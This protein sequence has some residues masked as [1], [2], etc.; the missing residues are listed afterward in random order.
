M[1]GIL[2]FVPLQRQRQRFTP[3]H[4]GDMP[5]FWLQRQPIA[6]HPHAC[7]GY[8]SQFILQAFLF[9]FTPTHV[10]DMR[11]SYLC[12]GRRSRFTPTHVGDILSSAS[13]YS[14]AMRFTPT[15]VGD[16][17]RD[18][19]FMLFSAVHPHACGGYCAR[20]ALR[21]GVAGSPPRMWGIYR[22][23]VGI[24]LA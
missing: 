16:I 17:K 13:A 20:I 1:W 4:V 23:T 11:H 22:Q 14:S 15:H 5:F 12:R 7:G 3:T 6:V 8:V 19:V 10:G 2:A 21:A 18:T 9:R 24:P